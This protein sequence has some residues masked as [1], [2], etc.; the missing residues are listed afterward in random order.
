[1]L[2][3]AYHN[4]IEGSSELRWLTSPQ[5]IMLRM[6]NEVDSEKRTRKQLVGL[7]K[8]LDFPPI[9]DLEDRGKEKLS[10]LFTAM[11]FASY[12]SIYLAILRRVDPAEP[13][14][15]PRFRAI[16]QRK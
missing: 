14:L 4:N 11:A 16:A 1:M 15:I 13:R 9:F 6:R 10:Q 5:P 2:P 8:E 3:E 12:V 7:L